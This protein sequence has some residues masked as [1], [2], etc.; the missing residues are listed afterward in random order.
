MSVCVGTANGV[1][2]CSLRLFLKLA[3]T[4]NTAAHHAVK[5]TVFVGCNFVLHYESKKTRHL[6]LAH[7]FTKY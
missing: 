7:N 5:H 3:V 4:I 2:S 6:T 1:S